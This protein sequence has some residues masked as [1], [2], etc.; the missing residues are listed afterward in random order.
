MCDTTGA[1]ASESGRWQ[2]RP[3]L[4]HTSATLL[5]R[6][7]EVSAANSVLAN[8]QELQRLESHT[9]LKGPALISAFDPCSR[10]RRAAAGALRVDREKEVAL[11][12]SGPDQRAY[13]QSDWVTNHTT[14]IGDG[15]RT[16]SAA[17]VLNEEV[18]TDVGSIFAIIVPRVVRLARPEFQ[19]IAGPGAEVIEDCG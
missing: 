16:A 15:K 1:V 12:W 10:V 2:K 8:R 4:S 9:C 13:E 14:G 17:L 6:L 18:D 11:L 5:T 3:L 7:A 19:A